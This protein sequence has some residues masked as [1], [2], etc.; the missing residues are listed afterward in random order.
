RGSAD[1]SRLS[2]LDRA[3]DQ[4]ALPR[5]SV[6]GWQMSVDHEELANEAAK[7]GDVL[8]SPDLP[9]ERGAVFC[10][11]RKTGELGALLQLR[12]ELG[13]V[14]RVLRPAFAELGA[15]LQHFAGRGGDRELAFIGMCEGRF[16]DDFDPIC[17]IHDSSV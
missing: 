4:A 10:T 12:V 5:L 6:I 9:G 8:E 11:E 13:I 3:A 17:K 7:V 2:R 15:G 14:W 16:G 1:L